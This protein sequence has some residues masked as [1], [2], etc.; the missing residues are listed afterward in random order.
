MGKKQEI[1]KLL[2]EILTKKS[3]T[4]RWVR[5]VGACVWVH[6][7]PGAVRNK[8]EKKQKTKA[9]APFGRDP[10]IQLFIKRQ[11]KAD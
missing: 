4:V 5:D 7:A 2:S 1:Y 6:G 9:D 3:E 10:F 8:Q 11:K